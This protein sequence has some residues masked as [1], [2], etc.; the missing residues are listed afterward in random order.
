MPCLKHVISPLNSA[1]SS[2]L[3]IYC[4]PNSYSNTLQLPYS[5]LSQ[6]QQRLTNRTNFYSLVAV[7]VSGTLLGQLGFERFES[8]RRQ[9]VINFG[10]AVT[11]AAQGQGIG[12]ALIEAM[13]DLAFNW[14]AIA[15]IELE[16][17]TDNKTAIHLYQKHGFVIEGTAQNYAFKNGRFADVYLMAVCRS[18]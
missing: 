2:C 12:S 6:W 4:E 11:A 9:H 14:L 5:S 15:R 16:V 8:P 10:M 17:Y 3:G 18:A 7:D 1:T 13:F